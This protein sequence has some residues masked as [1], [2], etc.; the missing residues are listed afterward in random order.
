MNAVRSIY[1]QLIAFNKDPPPNCSAGPKSDD[2]YHWTA[3]ILGPED[4]PY[5]GGVYFLDIHFNKYTP[6]RPPSIRFETKIYHPNIS[7]NG[8]IS[9]DILKDNWCPG[10]SIAKVLL[11]ISSLLT[12]LIRMI[13]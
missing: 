7:S 2:V 4:S 12:V 5:E 8:S 9:V 3:T 11:S 13:L 6:F 10:L 1:R